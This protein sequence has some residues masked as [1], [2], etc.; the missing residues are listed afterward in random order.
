LTLR[1]KSDILIKLLINVL[2]IWK[3]AV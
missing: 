2:L 3:G 1:I